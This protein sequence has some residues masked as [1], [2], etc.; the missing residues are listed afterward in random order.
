MFKT[1]V[2]L[3]SGHTSYFPSAKGSGRDTDLSPPYT[4]KVKN[5]WSSIP[6]S[7]CT[8]I[9]GSLIT[10]RTIYTATLTLTRT[11]KTRDH[12][13]YRHYPVITR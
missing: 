12:G 8:F 7:S 13:Y 2:S 1:Y 11:M 5:S 3:L 6:N 10:H 9:A 4:I